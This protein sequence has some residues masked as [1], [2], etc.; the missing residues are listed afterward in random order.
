LSATGIAT[1]VGSTAPAYSL[2]ATLGFIVATTGMGVHAP[3]VMLVA[4]VPILLVSLGYR[5]LK[6]GIPFMVLS[7]FKFREFFSRKTEVAPA[8][9]LHP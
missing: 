6:L 3:A 7:A 9:L 5:D 1:G 2:A 4:F 8:G